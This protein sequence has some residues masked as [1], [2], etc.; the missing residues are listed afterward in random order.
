MKG[1]VPFEKVH[2][3]TQ[4]PKFEIPNFFKRGRP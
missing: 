1:N 3:T 2:A 4:A